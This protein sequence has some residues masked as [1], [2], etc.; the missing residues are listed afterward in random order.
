M[1]PLPAMT[2]AQRK[3]FEQNIQRGREARQKKESMG[4]MCKAPKFIQFSQ[5]S[6]P[7]IRSQHDVNF[8]KYAKE[9]IDEKGWLSNKIPPLASSNFKN[10]VTNIVRKKYSR[11]NPGAP[12]LNS[13]SM[14]VKIAL[15]SIKEKLEKLN[16]TS[17]KAKPV[18]PKSKP[19][20]PKNPPRILNG[21]VI[22]RPAKITKKILAELK[23]KTARCRSMT[24]DLSTR[25]RGRP[26]APCNTF[27]ATSARC[28]KRRNH[29]IP[30]YRCVCEGPS[31]KKRTK[32]E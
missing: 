3:Q 13:D 32:K 7:A 8:E 12:E 29:P 9:M 20:S 28:F 26:P 10:T 30:E 5:V 4:R 16:K 6:K 17:P 25:P 21:G 1:P 11:N 31:P 23:P 24:T 18:S 19:V 27:P 15:R 14:F 22:R 2:K